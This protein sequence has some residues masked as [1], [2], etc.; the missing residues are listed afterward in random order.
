MQQGAG[1]NLRTGLRTRTF[2]HR[3]RPVAKHSLRRSAT[4]LGNEFGFGWAIARGFVPDVGALLLN[5]RVDEGF[6][7]RC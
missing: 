2:L 1:T 6:L 7:R 4:H 3:A 5:D